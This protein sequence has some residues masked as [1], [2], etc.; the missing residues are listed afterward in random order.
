MS[1]V[2][3]GT[4]YGFTAAELAILEADGDYAD[5]VSLFNISA[6]IG[7]VDYRFAPASAIG[8]AMA[9]I[10]RLEDD[11]TDPTG[12]IYSVTLDSAVYYSA[13]GFKLIP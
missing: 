13:F 3:G 5:I 1:L 10:G 11:E 2:N 7:G 6:T 4:Y 12:Q 8:N 9:I